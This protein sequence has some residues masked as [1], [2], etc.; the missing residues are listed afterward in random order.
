MG[1]TKAIFFDID[2]TLIDF[3]EDEMPE[4]TKKALRKVQE[5]GHKIFICTG[6][7]KK[8]VSKCL[9][10]FGFD[11]VVCSAG[12]YVEYEGE[13]I[14]NKHIPT[15]ALA[16]MIAYF[17]KNDIVYILM[18]AKRLLATKENRVS[19]CKRFGEDLGISWQE[20]AELFDIWE[21][22]GD[23]LQNISEYDDIETGMYIQSPI[24]IEEVRAFLKPEIHITASS[25]RGK[26]DKKSGEFTQNGITKATGIHE[27]IQYLHIPREDSIAVGDGPNDLDMLAFAGIGVAMGN[28]I[29]E[30]KSCSDMVT[31]CINEDGIYNAMKSLNLL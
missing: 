22:E 13:V 11:G 14:W 25:Y 16:K 5:N 29:D 3:G 10:D 9:L 8:Q 26:K 31:D 30:V 2:G 15:S 7:C 6:R 19:I 23:V 12:A 20:A 4:S 18:G 1:R 17:E 27:M 24:L 28:A 21:T